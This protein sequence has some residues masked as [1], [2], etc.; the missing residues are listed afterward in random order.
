[1]RQHYTST[2][3][4]PPIYNEH[5]HPYTPPYP[6]AHKHTRTRVHIHAVNTH[7]HIHIHINMYIHTNIYTHMHINMYIHIIAQAYTVCMHTINQQEIL[8]RSESRFEQ[9]GAT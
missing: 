4:V 9:N 8:E 1:M 7:I 3:S 6:H 5:Y 2:V